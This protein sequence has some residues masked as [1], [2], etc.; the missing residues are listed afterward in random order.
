[1]KKKIKL[2]KTDSYSE[3]NKFWNEENLRGN[4]RLDASGSVSVFPF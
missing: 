2:Q 1:M 4:E 3:A